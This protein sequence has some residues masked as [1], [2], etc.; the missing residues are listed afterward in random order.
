MAQIEYTQE[1]AYEEMMQGLINIVGHGYLM[2][3]W[4]DSL[5]IINPYIKLYDESLWANMCV[6][7]KRLDSTLKK[8]SKTFVKN[9]EKSKDI[10]YEQI[11]KGISAMAKMSPENRVKFIK[12]L[13]ILSEKY[14]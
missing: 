8:I 6:T 12:E 3:G 14:K 4:I 5:Y 10:M 13:E 7:Q 1:Q 9:D 2:S 11:G